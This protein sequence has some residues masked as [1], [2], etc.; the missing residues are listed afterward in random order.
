VIGVQGNRCH[1]RAEYEFDGTVASHQELPK[2][3][4]QESSSTGTN[5]KRDRHADGSICPIN[6]VRYP[7]GH[8]N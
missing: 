8:W 2:E 3:G 1:E 7:S 6:G 5:D 4:N